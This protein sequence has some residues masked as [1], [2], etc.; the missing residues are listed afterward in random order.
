MMLKPGQL[1]VSGEGLVVEVVSLI[2]SGGQGEVYRVNVDGQGYALKWYHHPVTDGQVAVAVEQRRALTKY[3]LVNS[4]P[5]SRFLWPI[6]FVD[7][8]EGRTYGYLMP[9]LA[10]R[11]SGLESLVLGKMRPVPSFRV[12]CRAAIGLSECFRKLH[13]MGACYKDI[14]LGGPVIDPTNGDVMVCDL[15]NVRINKTPGNILFVFFAAPELIRGEG[16]CQT[17]TDIHSLAV[18]LFYMFIRQHPLDGMQQLKVNV[19]NE[20]AQRKFYGKQ[21]V[22]IFDPDNDTNRPVPGFHDHAIRNWSIY[23]HF[24]QRLFTRS[25][26]EG[27]HEPALRVREGEWM[28]AFSRLR[29]SLFYCS[30]CGSENF[31]DFERNVE[32]QQQPCW[33]C[34]VSTP[35]PMRLELGDRWILLNHNTALYGHHL[36]RRL[37]FSRALAQ[38]SQHPQDERKWGLTNLSKESWTYRARDGGLKE[39]A[40]GRSVPLRSGLVVNF[41]RRE[42]VIRLR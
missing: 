31:Y 16:S 42:G 12:L 17:N 9:L 37:D 39:C 2:G 18:L 26:T 32:G 19:F 29:D 1:L 33:R 6:G 3:L 7:E 27:L 22:F 25:F 13:N 34:G 35:M 40:P 30:G 21:P 14:N 41:G 24:L 23:P 15:D 5:D 36:G 4:P 20:A 28:E 11:F 8:A 10:D 38:V